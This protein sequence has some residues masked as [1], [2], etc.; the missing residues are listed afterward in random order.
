MNEREPGGGCGRRGR[1]RPRVRR[2][3]GDPGAFR[4]F[5]PLCGRPDEVVIVLP[6]EVEALR[7]VDLQ[8]LEQEEAALAL[9]ISRKTLWRDLHEARRKVAD[10]LVHGKTIRIVGCGRRGE[11]GCPDDEGGPSP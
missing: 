6:E 10:A 7:L 2:M 4:C 1:G 8:G 3:I 9:G 11:E 5:G